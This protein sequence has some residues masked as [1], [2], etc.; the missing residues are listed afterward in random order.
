MIVLL[1]GKPF[2]LRGEV[3]EHYLEQGEP[4][5]FAGE[6]PLASEGISGP[7]LDFN[8][9]TQRSRAT[10]QVSIVT[11]SQTPKSEGVAYVLRG[12]WRLQGVEYQAGEGIWWQD[13]RPGELVPH[14][15]DAALILADIRRV[16][17]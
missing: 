6:W 2:W 10:A 5:A 17:R 14:S 3:A 15:D 12:C 7:G 11:T 8:I 4:W 9:M 13:E 16:E 1:E